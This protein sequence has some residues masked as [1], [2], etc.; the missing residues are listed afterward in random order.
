VENLLPYFRSILPDKDITKI[1]EAYAIDPYKV[2]EKYKKRYF[3]KTPD[4]RTAQVMNLLFLINGDLLQ[5]KNHK[6]TFFVYFQKIMEEL[7]RLCEPISYWA[8]DLVISKQDFIERITKSKDKIRGIVNERITF[9]G[10]AYSGDR[11]TKNYPSLLSAMVCVRGC[12]EEMIEWFF[13]MFPN[14]DVNEYLYVAMTDHF[15]C[16]IW[17]PFLH[18]QDSLC[19]AI[20]RQ[21]GYDPSKLI[22]N[23]FSLPPSHKVRLTTRVEKILA[24]ANPE[25]FVLQE[26]HDT[27]QSPAQFLAKSYS[28]DPVQVRKAMR[29]FHFAGEDASRVLCLFF[30]M[31]GGFLQIKEL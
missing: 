6:K 5:I 8:P 1:F 31:D 21:P 18:E 9:K 11:Y 24:V 25:N 29:S 15:D 23:L 26:I 16:A 12:D 4:S 13:R 17:T 2:Q 28:E 3:L 27:P 7:Q 10:E 30:L 22:S 19:L 20:A 14:A